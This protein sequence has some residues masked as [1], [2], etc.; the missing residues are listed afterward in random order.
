VLNEELDNLKLPQV[1]HEPFIEKFLKILE[2]SDAFHQASY[3]LLMARIFELALLCAGHYAD[4]A[5]FSAAGDLL[6]NPRKVLIHQKGH[7]HS[8]VK[9][10]HGKISDQ[11]DNGQRSRKHLQ[12]LLKH[13]VALEIAQPA[14]LP[15]LFERMQHSGKIAPWYL[16]AAEQRLKQI[17]ATIGFLSAL[18]VFSFEDLHRRLQASSPKTVQFVADH[19]CRFDTQYFKRL[20]REIQK[21]IKYSNEKS[22]FVTNP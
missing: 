4:N 21:R 19:L 7:S 10:R 16:H 14:I 9:Q 22:E 1:I 6:V 11:L 12:V 3:W 20:G 17:A 5:E 13:E 18:P 2:A 15:H 8:L